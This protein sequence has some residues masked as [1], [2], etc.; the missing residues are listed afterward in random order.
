VRQASR[1]P[2]AARLLAPLLLTLAALLA[3]EAL[4]GL[5]LFFAR[6]AA[7]SMPGEAVHVFAGLALTLA[8][9]LYQWSHWRRVWP[10]R[11]R[12][13]YVLGVIA[14]LSM[15][16]ALATGLLLGLAWWRGR[17][18]TPAFAPPLVA[19]HNVTSML[20]LTFALSHLGA[21]LQRDARAASRR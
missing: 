12:L 14:A 13:D 15:I 5:V 8:Y 6:L 4:G 19:A 9:A 18:G 1:S 17:E 11:A 16:A 7:G 10:L 20:V 3:F 21:V 2:R